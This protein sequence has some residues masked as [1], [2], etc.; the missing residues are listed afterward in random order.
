MTR[1]GQRVVE[2]VRPTA[3]LQRAAGDQEPHGAWIRRYAA[4]ATTISTSCMP[5]ALGA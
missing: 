4:Y 2:R 1:V 5:G 3:M